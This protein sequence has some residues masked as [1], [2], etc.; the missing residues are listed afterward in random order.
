MN[1]YSISYVDFDTI[2]SLCIVRNCLLISMRISIALVQLVLS[3]AAEV[4]QT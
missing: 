4:S 3:P 2:Y 1:I